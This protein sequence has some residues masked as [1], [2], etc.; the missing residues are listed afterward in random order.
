M[1][2][3]SFNPSK[4]GKWIAILLTCLAGLAV[5]L[6][7]SIL[8]HP[9]SVVVAKADIEEASLIQA[10]QLELVKVAKKDCQKGT[11]QRIEDVAGGVAAGS[12]FAGQQIIDRQISGENVAGELA[13]GSIKTGQ[14]IITLTT[15]QATWSS[16]LRVGDLVTV[17]GVY[18]AESAV[19]E[20]AVGRVT[21]P[22]AGSVVRN[23]K[24]I[25]EA[26]STS[27]NQTEISFV[28][29]TEGGKRVLLAL[30]T[31]QMVYLL[32]RHPD[33]GGVE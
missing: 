19:R 9:V 28:T 10:E 1:Q 27:P 5:Y 30:K 21:K 18:P 4:K 22:S 23:L 16:Q 25:Q 17:V 2:Y 24:N 14:T 8:F 13:L 7:V 32:P 12:I 11:Y 26:Q 20:E 31:S 33:L 6:S 3:K 15:Q 29:D